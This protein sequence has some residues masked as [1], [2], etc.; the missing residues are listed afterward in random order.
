MH[1]PHLPLYQTPQ[2]HRR[3]LSPNPLQ[4][5]QWSFQTTIQ[6]HFVFIPSK[7]SYPDPHFLLHTPSFQYTISQT[8]FDYLFIYLFYVDSSFFGYLELMEHKNESLDFS[9][10]ITLSLL[11][12]VRLYPW[13][14]YLISLFLSHGGIQTLSLCGSTCRICTKL[15]EII[16]D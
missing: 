9:V 13:I 4:Q 7:T 15:P 14:C 10:E 1:S 3:H 6:F 16:I 11:P 12:F 5:C 2:R 8:L